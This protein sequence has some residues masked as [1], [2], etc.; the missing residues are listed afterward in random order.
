MESSSSPFTNLT[1]LSHITQIKL[2][3]KEVQ[4]EAFETICTII[5]T[6]QNLNAQQT[7]YFKTHGD[8]RNR[9]TLCSILRW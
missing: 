5:C 1:L 8:N 3:S 2:A 9:S 6:K 7:T 4:L